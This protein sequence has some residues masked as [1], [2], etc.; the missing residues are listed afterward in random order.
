MEQV[1]RKEV[2]S[3]TEENHILTEK[4]KSSSNEDRNDVSL[5]LTYETMLVSLSL[6]L[7]TV[8]SS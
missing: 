8:Y 1:L 7:F 4:L 6:S 2:L 5:T 3:L